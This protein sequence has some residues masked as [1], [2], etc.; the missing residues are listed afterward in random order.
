MVKPSGSEEEGGFQALLERVEGKVDA[1][2][3][4]VVSFGG[5]IDGVANEFDRRLDTLDKKLELHTRTIL[6]ELRAIGLR[7][8]AHERTHLG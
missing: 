2:G 4:Q 1:F 5:K 6:S 8:D 7:L 3:E